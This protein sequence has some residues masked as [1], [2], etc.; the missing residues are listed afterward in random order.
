MSDQDAR[1]DEDNEEIS[2]DEQ[3]PDEDLEEGGGKKIN[4][5]E[6]YRGSGLPRLVRSVNQKRNCRQV[7]CKLLPIN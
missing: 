5:D 2:E 6:M 1:P 3:S 7:S 4:S